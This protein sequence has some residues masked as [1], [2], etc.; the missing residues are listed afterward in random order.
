MERI[1]IALVVCLVLNACAPTN[2]DTTTPSGASTLCGDSLVWN[3]G[4]TYK[5]ES[6]KSLDQL[7]PNMYGHAGYVNASGV[8]VNACYYAII[9][10]VAPHVDQE[11]IYLNR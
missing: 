11:P 6:D 3:D 8:Q 9:P 7:A 5:V 2:D 1:M 4:I 10:G